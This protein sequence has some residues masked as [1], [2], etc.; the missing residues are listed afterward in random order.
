MLSADIEAK[1][2]LLQDKHNQEVQTFQQ[3]LADTEICCAEVLE[4]QSAEV[5]R[6]QEGW[7]KLQELQQATPARNACAVCFELADW[8]IIPCG[9]TSYCQA[10]G[11][12]RAR[13][14]ERSGMDSNCS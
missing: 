10:H 2:L 6:L 14:E 9:H 7:Q 12:A 13:E 11:V 4:Q 3:M 8:A 1:M 5:Q